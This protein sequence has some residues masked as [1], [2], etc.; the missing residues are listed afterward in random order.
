MEGI[1]LDS[2]TL[3]VYLA[4]I[5]V[6]FLVGRIFIIPVKAIGKLVINSIL[7]GLL[8]YVINL[9]GQNVGF[10]IGLN[11]FTAIFVGLLGVPR[12]YIFNINKTYSTVTDFARLRGLSTSK[13]F[14]F[15]IKY[16]SN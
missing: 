9:I 14:S 11:I 2:T 10:H 12:K 13:L 5:I 7:G 8:I 3:I 16:E 4:C 6:L 15:V 1:N